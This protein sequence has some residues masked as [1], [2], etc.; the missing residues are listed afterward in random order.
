LDI[1]RILIIIL[2]FVSVYVLLFVWIMILAYIHNDIS[3][4]TIIN[5]AQFA[6]LLTLLTIFAGCAGAVRAWIK[7]DSPSEPLEKPED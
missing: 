7:E 2:T 4:T 3:M 5:A 1:K 6:I